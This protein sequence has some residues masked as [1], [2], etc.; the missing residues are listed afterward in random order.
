MGG[1]RTSNIVTRN[2]IFDAQGRMPSDARQMKLQAIMIMTI[3]PA[4]YKMVQHRK[5]TAYES[6]QHLPEQ[7]YIFRHTILSFIPVQQ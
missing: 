3:V 6:G 4:G 5:N 2:N 1:G 7:D